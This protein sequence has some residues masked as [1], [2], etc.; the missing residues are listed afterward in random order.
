MVKIRC[1]DRTSGHSIRPKCRR[2]RACDLVLGRETS[3]WLWPNVYLHRHSRPYTIIG[4]KINLLYLVNHLINSLIKW[5]LEL[6][7]VDEAY[8]FS[9]YDDVVTRNWFFIPDLTV[10]D[11][12][13]LE[14]L[15]I[16]SRIRQLFPTQMLILIHVS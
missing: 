6:L 4:L 1:K 16:T 9:W 10:V 15:E 14:V 13:L 8:R 12:M 5:W 2:V 3:V 11:S 7:L